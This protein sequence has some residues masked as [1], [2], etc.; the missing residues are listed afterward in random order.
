MAR[1]TCKVC[2]KRTDEGP[3]CNEC[4]AAQ[5]GSVNPLAQQPEPAPFRDDVLTEDR[6]LVCELPRRVIQLPG[7][8][9]AQPPPGPQAPPPPP[10]PDPGSSFFDDCPWLWVERDRMIFC[11][12]KANGVLRLKLS[13]HAEGLE[14]VRVNLRFQGGGA[15]A[16]PWLKPK[17]GQAK[18]VKLNIPPLPPG[19]HPAELRLQF[20]KDNQI[21]K[22]ETTMELYVY[23]SD[24]SAG[25]IAESIVFNITNDIKTGHAS[26]VHLS[27]DAASAF[28]KFTK[29]GQAH[30]LTDLLNLM[31]SEMRAYRREEL[32]EAGCEIKPSAPTPP[33]QE[34]LAQRLTLVVG[35]RL[36]HLI[37]SRRVTLGK[38]RDNH[39]VTRLF[40]QQ[41]VAD[42][43]RCERI[44]KFHCTLELEGTT[45]VLQDG[46]RDDCGRAKPSTWGVSWQGKAVQGSLRIPVETLP[47]RGQLGLVN[48]AGHSDF[49]LTVC[50]Q[51]FD[52]TQCS[53]C[54]Q[55][56]RHG[57]SNGRTPALLLRRT[58]Q[59]PEHY[60][61]AWACFDLG[62]V[63]PECAGRVV[64]YEQG[65]FS[66]RATGT[67]DWL[68]PGRH[69]GR[70][71]VRPFTQYGL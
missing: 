43:Q 60:L 14:E 51:A 9:R 12:E 2:G 23:P 54:Q 53:S 70:I 65:A 25:K 21:L 3:F 38:N 57:C 36:L 33:P 1:I 50:P 40:N 55:Q 15:S 11:V 4:G 49:E 20:H 69:L 45:C 47:T 61:L 46:A 42:A 8:E 22:F 29:N 24:S 35:G 5:D 16:T 63:F 28:E 62:T 26:D 41:G 27:Q 32:Y 48:N 10:Q 58:D 17:F 68:V 18:E 19:A 37:A 44:S 71:E 66:L 30:A 59:V 64:C 34:A 31:N 56:A 7:Q 6:P 39:I 13:A 52:F 67:F